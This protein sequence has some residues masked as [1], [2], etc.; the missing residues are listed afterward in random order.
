MTVKFQ[1]QATADLVMLDRHAHAVL[2]L[3]GKSEVG[4]GILEPKDMPAALTVFKNLPQEANHP[5]QEE[6]LTGA[7]AADAEIDPT[8]QADAADRPEPPEPKFMNEYVSLRKRAWPLVMM[9]E[10]A[11]KENKPIVWNVTY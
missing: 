4:P 2:Q 7:V 3:L 1:S 8:L 6:A 9:I 5:G 10:R 11:L